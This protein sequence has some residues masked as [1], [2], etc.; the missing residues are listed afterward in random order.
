MVDRADGL[1]IGIRDM[2][3]SEI[4]FRDEECGNRSDGQPPANSG[5]LFVSVFPGG[6]SPGPSSDQQLGMDEIHSIGIG[7]TQRTGII[8]DD[9][10]FKDALYVEKGCFTIVQ[11]ILRVM[12]TKAGKYDVLQT[13]NENISNDGVLG[14]FTEP[15]D[16]VSD[17]LQFVVKD[18]D[19]FFSEPAGVDHGLKCQH[20]GLFVE[21]Q[22]SGA[23][24]FESLIG[25]GV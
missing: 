21:M 19:W 14:K 7:I 4:P 6:L 2:L 1:A 10:M 5:Q 12:R 24:Y 17:V 9:R 8:P 18:H 11:K 16:F 20:H 13:V 22:Y 25:V 15:L 3:R 23:R